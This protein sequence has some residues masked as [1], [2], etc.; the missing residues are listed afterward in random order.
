M[1]YEYPDAYDVIVV[2]AGHAGCEAALAAARMGARVLALTG[3]LDMVAQ[4]S[5]NPA[6]GGV[7]KG[8][9]VKELDAL[10]G[11]MA[12]VIDQTGIQYRRLNASKGPAVRSTRAQ[13]DKRRYRDEMRMRLERCD[14][15]A[16]RQGEVAA[17]GVEDG[18][19]KGVVTT[20][21]V[22]Y[23]A[24]AVIMTTGTFL[25]GAIFVGEA[26]AAGGRAGEA[27]SISLSGSLAEIG[28]PLA[29]LKTGTPCRL[30]RRTIDVTGLEVQPG[31]EPPPMFRWRRTRYAPPLPQVPCWVT[32]TNEK[33]HAVIRANLHR[34]PLFS[35]KEGRKE[36]EGTGPRYCPS[37]EDKVVRFADK[38]RHQIYLEPEGVEVGLGGAGEVYPNGVSTSLPF[39]V[40]LAFIRTIPGLERAEMTR[41]GYA[42]E[43]DFIDPREVW[44]TLETRRVRGLYHAG[45][46]NGT[47]GYEEAAIQGLLAGINAAAKL[48]FGAGD[49]EPVIIR[50]DQGYA[51]VLVDD[52]V[53]QGTKE[54]YRIMT[55]RAEFRLLLREDNAADRLMPLGRKLGLIDDDRW[56]DYTAWQAELADALTRANSA[57]VTGTPAVN[58]LLAKHGSSP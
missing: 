23:R 10:G 37:I 20:M 28:F 51:G 26:R 15:L 14:R 47:S 13:A 43:Y 6:I 22:R 49:R 29:R 3:S 44:P 52:L 34:S 40:Q 35:L 16:L 39:D 53:T 21:G 2:G 5:C 57:S 25:R 27:P 54:P 9:L 31:D 19:I 42:V 1:T 4:M 36:I 55:S 12:S 30:D 24:R 58:D 38:D 33:T 41:P 7:A 48:G 45:Q 11:E 8:H 46:I 56:R 17:L 18:E 50:R 32:Y